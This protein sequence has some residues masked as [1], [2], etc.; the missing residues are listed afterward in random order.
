MYENIVEGIRQEKR[1]EQFQRSQMEETVADLKRKLAS[2]DEGGDHEW[3]TKK[4]RLRNEQALQL[5]HQLNV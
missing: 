5:T 4:L 3:E 1:I 2:K